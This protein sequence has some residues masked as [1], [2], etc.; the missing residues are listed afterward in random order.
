MK[1]EKPSK[2]EYQTAA[3]YRSTAKFFADITHSRKYAKNP[4][5]FALMCHHLS[6]FCYSKAFKSNLHG[7]SK[8]R[9]NL[10]KDMQAAHNC[11]PPNKML[12]WTDAAHEKRQMTPSHVLQ[13]LE[14]TGDAIEAQRQIEHA[15]STAISLPIESSGAAGFNLTGFT[16]KQVV[17][18]A[19]N[20]L[21]VFASNHFQRREPS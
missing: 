6:A 2:S 18:Y 20:A 16:P 21:D 17:E 1:L 7:L 10:K 4:E 14:D 9:E 3:F 5:A 8:L 11:S 15:M 13:Y 12:G 19:K